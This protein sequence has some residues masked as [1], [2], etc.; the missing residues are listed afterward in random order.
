MLVQDALQKG[1][2]MKDY[3]LQVRL[4]LAEKETLAMAAQAA[5][6]SVSA[7]VRERIRKAARTELQ[8]AG[9]RVPFLQQELD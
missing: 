1:R 6:L 4:T 9:I 2:R 7:W 3:N 5:G 8:D